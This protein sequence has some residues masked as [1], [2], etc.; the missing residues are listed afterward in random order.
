MTNQCKGHLGRARA[1]LAQMPTDRPFY[2]NEVATGLTGGSWGN[3]VS[4][5]LLMKVGRGGPD[6][7]RRI[8]WQLTARAKR[9]LG[10]DGEEKA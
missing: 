1:I 7:G 8:K 2:A 5:D 9:L 10:K 6:R 4:R 3:L